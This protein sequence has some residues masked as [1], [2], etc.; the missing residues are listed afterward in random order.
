MSC[1][2][3]LC[4][5]LKQH[6]KKDLHVP[7]VLLV[8]STSSENTLTTMMDLFFLWQVIL[9]VLNKL[10]LFIDETYVIF[11]LFILYFVVL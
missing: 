5:A 2:L 10:A 6:L 7:V 1:W 3:K 11:T 9:Q 4:S 8:E